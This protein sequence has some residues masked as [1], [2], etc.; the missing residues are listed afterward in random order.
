[1]KGILR[2]RASY[3]YDRKKF[4]S[5]RVEIGEG[6]IGQCY[7]EAQTIYMAKVPNNYLP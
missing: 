6:I 5:K 7:L 2:L 3:A 1:M 4:I